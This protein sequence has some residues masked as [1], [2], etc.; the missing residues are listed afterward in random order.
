LTGVTRSP[1]TSEDVASTSPSVNPTA[2]PD[3]PVRPGPDPA[4]A[5]DGSSGSRVAVILVTLVALGLVSAT[6]ARVAADRSGSAG[7]ADTVA[8]LAGVVLDEPRPRPD[9]TLT[10][11]EGRPFDFRAETEGRLTLLFFGYT[12]CPDICPIHLATLAS[13]LDR[14]G[15]P[16]P[17][18]VFV[19]V[20]PGRDTPEAV[21]AYL[22]RFDRRFIGLTG[23]AE[24]LVRA[25]E[26]AAI[27]VAVVE[28]GVG[29]D[30]YLVGHA[31]QVMAYT[32][33]DLGHVV[34]PFGVRQQ[35][36]AHD[37]PRLAA[38]LEGHGAR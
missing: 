28:P 26:A 22:D 23:T 10:D 20:D 5:P 17:L 7:A 15:M 32:A 35:D 34:Y 38:G 3:A 6:V 24:E 1:G 2:P 31:S 21:R 30:D 8:D 14:S 11:T 12:S 37:L 18:V 33:D 16:Q 19:G 27:P 9:F 13:T 36:W 4:G 25:Q 29:E